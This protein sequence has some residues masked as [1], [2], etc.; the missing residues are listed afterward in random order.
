MCVLI[1]SDNYFED[2]NNILMFITGEIIYLMFIVCQVFNNLIDIFILN[3][4]E[5]EL[6]NKA[7]FQVFFRYNFLIKY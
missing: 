7:T 6:E 5:I 1:V 4:I 2:G 3:R